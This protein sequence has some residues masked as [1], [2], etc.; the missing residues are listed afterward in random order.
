MR[1]YIHKLGC[2]KNDVDADY[3]ADLLRGRQPDAAPFLQRAGD[4]NPR[5]I[6]L[7]ASASPEERRRM[8]RD[9]DCSLELDRFD[10][11]MQV[12]LRDGWLGMRKIPM[13]K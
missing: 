1:F 5:L 8:R 2:P 12:T 3:I 11:A 13:A 9:I 6:D 4:L 10:F 7:F